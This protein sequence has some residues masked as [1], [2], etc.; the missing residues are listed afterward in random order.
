MLPHMPQSTKFWE[1]MCLNSSDIT[2]LNYTVNLQRQLKTIS[3]R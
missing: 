2:E 1:D 3:Q